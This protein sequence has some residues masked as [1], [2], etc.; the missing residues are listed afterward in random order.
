M[1][2]LAAPAIEVVERRPRCASTPSAGRASTSTGWRTSGPGASRASSGGATGSRSGTAAT[3]RPTSASEPPEG[4][5]W[6]RDARR[7]RHLVQLG[8]VAVRDARL[9]RRH[10]GAARLLP[11]RRARHGARHHLPLGRA[12]G[13]D[14]ARVHRRRP[15]RRR[16]RPLGDPGARRAADVEVA[17]HR[18][19]TRSTRSTRTAPTRCASA[20]W[21]CPRP[22]TCASREAKVQQGRDLANKLWNASR[23]VLLNGP[24]RRRAGAAPDARSRTAGSSRGCSA[25]SARVSERDRGLRLRARR[26]R[27][28]R[29]LLVGALRLVPRDRQAAALRRRRGRRRRRCSACSSRRSRSPTRDAVRD[30]GDLV[31]TCPAPSRG[32]G[33]PSVPGGR[34]RRWSTRRPRREIGAGDRAD[35]RAARAGAT[36]PASPVEQVLARAAP[37][38]TTRRTSSSRGS[39]GSSSTRATAASR[40]RRVGGGRAARR[41]TASTPRPSRRGSRSGARSCAPRSKRAEG[42]LANEGFVAKAP[43]EVVEAER[44]K[45]E[46]LPGRARGAGRMSRADA[47]ELPASLE[48]FGWRSG[49][50]G[51]GGSDRCS[52]CRRTASPRSTSS[53]PTASPR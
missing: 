3:T 38:A 35:P 19:S 4:E 44:E 13:H 16:L 21:R 51:C 48:L 11:D 22:R 31:A 36:W 18:A 46:R 23:L 8:A 42:K 2:E 1:D 24:R 47:E 12:D 17:R 53:A 9:A 27:A 20:C 39:P 15:V 6:E 37:T 28:L 45:L 14:G 30:R 25:R 7:A 26:A 40:S 52:G 29:L 34:R 32:A 10:A 50:S 49:W 43:A 5:G 33:R 41:P